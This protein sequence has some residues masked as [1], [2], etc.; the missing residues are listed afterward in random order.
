MNPHT[1]HTDISV[2]F[3]KANIVGLAGFGEELFILSKDF[4]VLELGERYCTSATIRV[5]H[6]FRSTG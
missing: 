2:G 1:F 4:V 3:G 6:G 5:N